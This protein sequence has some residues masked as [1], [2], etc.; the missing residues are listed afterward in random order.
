MPGAAP[1]LEFTN[2]LAIAGWVFMGLWLGVLALMTWVLHRDGPHPSQPAWLQHGA[3]WLFWL[4]GIPAA[5]GVF[6]EPITRLRIGADGGVTITRRSLFGR[7]EERHPPGSIAA[8]E[9]R[10]AKDSDG[11]ITFRTTLVARDG[12]ERLVR[13]G[14]DATVQEALAQ[15]LRAP[16]GLPPALAESSPTA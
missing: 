5:A 7:Q 9:V 4:I 6:A 12:R 16:L 10:Q 15:R 2:R 1:R 8:V 3:I 14:P 13:E 11:D